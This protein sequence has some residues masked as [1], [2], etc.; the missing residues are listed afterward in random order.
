MRNEQWRQSNHPVI[1]PVTF[2]AAEAWGAKHGVLPRLAYVQLVQRREAAIRNERENPYEAQLEPP[3]WNLIRAL[4]GRKLRPTLELELAMERLRM[5]SEEVAEG[6]RKA[7]GFDKRASSVLVLGGNRVAKTTLGMR[8]FAETVREM[9]GARAWAF[10]SNL[11]QSR[12]Y[13]MLPV[14]NYLPAS[15]RKRSPKTKQEYVAFKEAT[16]FA[17]EKF[18]LPNGSRGLFK[19]YDQDRTRAIEG[20]N[21]DFV[22]ADEVIPPDWVETLEFRTAERGGHMFVGFTPVEGYSGTVQLFLDGATVT[23]WELARLIPLDGKD[24][25]VAGQLGLTEAELAAYEA[26]LD[27]P[28]KAPYPGVLTRWWDVYA[29]IGSEPKADVVEMRRKTVDG[30]VWAELPVVARCVGT[31]T[32]RAVVW[33]HSHNNPWGNPLEIWRR[34]A[35][36]DRDAKLSRFYGFATKGLTRK[37]AAFDRKVHVLPHGDLVK[38]AAAGKAAHGAKWGSVYLV[39]DPASARNWA[40]GWALACETGLYWIEEWPS[41]VTPIPGIGV[42]GEWVLPDGKRHDGRPGPATKGL[43]W[44]V[45][46]YWEEARR[47]EALLVAEG[48]P[49]VWRTLMDAR[50]AATPTNGATS[51]KTLMD[52]CWEMGWMVE[53]TS[54]QTALDG[55]DAID[56]GEG[57]ITSALYWDRE[58]PA[59]WDNRPKMFLS[60]RC[61]NLEYCLENH[62]GLDGLKGATKDFVDLPRMALLSGC[63]HTAH[64]E[65]RCVT[66]E[67]MEEMRERERARAE[68]DRRG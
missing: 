40:M 4:L 23:R 52:E 31:A 29:W 10:H 25:D 6:L 64:R 43:G 37:F 53:A 32:N 50:F 24:P 46:R 21:C 62:T 27:D 11:D 41:Q 58:K 66:M 3:W 14:F 12:E 35:N 16:G 60:D 48:F 49:P 68:R 38:M 61:K 8:L 51:V 13:H 2:E 47:I 30:R 67:E 18:I 5:T 65:V 9:Q 22:E 36:K 45:G 33:V 20:G 28:G 15:L 63:A 19:S 42:L 39:V 55:R 54:T 1:P 26:W 56:E 17:N 44:S 34:I 57:M 7:C 59:G